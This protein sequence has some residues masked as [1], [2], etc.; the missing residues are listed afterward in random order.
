[1]HPQTDE[2]PALISSR[3][4]HDLASPLM[5][6]ANGLELLEMSGLGASPEAA[7]VA[8]SVKAARARME[9]FRI[10]FGAAGTGTLSDRKCA[11]ALSHNYAERKI[12]VRWTGDVAIP[13]AE[14][15]L[16]FLL[17]LCAEAAMPRGGS[18]TVSAFDGDCQVR[19]AATQFKDIAALWDTLRQGEGAVGAAEVQFKLA[20]AA[21]RDLGRALSVEQTGDEILL[22]AT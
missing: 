8:D 4:C 3:I 18:I 19:A 7:L 9:V 5:A 10:A 6:I 11:E 22:R 21:A 2:L 16:A 20:H 12:D 13:R 15:K 17:V 14:A 1:M